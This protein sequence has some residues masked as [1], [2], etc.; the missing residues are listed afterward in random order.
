VVEAGLFADFI[1]GVKES[2][3][4]LNLDAV[5]RYGFRWSVGFPLASLLHEKDFV[6]A[7]DLVQL[8]LDDFVHG[9]LH[10]ATDESGFDG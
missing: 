3:L 8:D 4:I 1:E 9:G 10:I 5:L 7:I 6:R 2:R